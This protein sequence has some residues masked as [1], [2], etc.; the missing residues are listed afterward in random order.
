MKAKQWNLPKAYASLD[1]MLADPSIEAV[2]NVLPVGVRCQWT[3]RALLAGK[4]VLSETPICV[5]A[6][7][8]MAAQRAA[9][10]M[11]KVLLEGTHP[12]AHPVTKRVREM[13]LQGKIGTLE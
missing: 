12:T 6:M 1:E 9:E 11:G 4:H 2:Y 13:I 3:V 10:D 5:N 7:E 8:A